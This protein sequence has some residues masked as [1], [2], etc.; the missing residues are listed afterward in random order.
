MAIKDIKQR[1]PGHGEVLFRE[2]DLANKESIHTF[3]KQCIQEESS[4]HILINNAGNYDVITN[5]V[6]Y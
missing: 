4:L 1:S 3:A 5:I 2:L 6:T